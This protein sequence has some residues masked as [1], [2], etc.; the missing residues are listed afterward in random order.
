LE[1]LAGFDRTYGD[2]Q[3]RSVLRPDTP[4]NRSEIQS[5]F[6]AVCRHH[7]WSEYGRRTKETVRSIVDGTPLFPVVRKLY[8]KVG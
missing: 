8:Q 4:E 3:C 7:L 6:S 5:D 1:L 2:E